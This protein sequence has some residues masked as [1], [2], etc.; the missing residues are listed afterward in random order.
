MGRCILANLSN[1][2]SSSSELN[3]A[4]KLAHMCAH[5]CAGTFQ[6]PDNRVG[7]IWI[8][9]NKLASGDSVEIDKLSVRMESVILREIQSE[10]GDAAFTPDE[11]KERRVAELQERSTNRMADKTN[12]QMEDLMSVLAEFDNEDLSDNKTIEDDADDLTKIR[13]TR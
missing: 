4:S 11:L 5:M 10:V 8:L 13:R 2:S 3:F 6:D 12:V 7:Y 9:G 1:E